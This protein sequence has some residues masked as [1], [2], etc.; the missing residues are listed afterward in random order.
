MLS[1]PAGR[2]LDPP[3]FLK[4]LGCCVSIVALALL[5]VLT[6]LPYVYNPLLF[7]Y[8]W[9]FLALGLVLFVVNKLLEWRH[10]KRV[11]GQSVRCRTCG[12]TGVGA[13]W[14]RS[15]C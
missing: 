1:R 11:R 15:E 8:L 3:V 4:W 10:S 7:L 2:G 5:V 9:R 14:L 6:T 12:W 13:L